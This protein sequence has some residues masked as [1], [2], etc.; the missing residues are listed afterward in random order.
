MYSWLY[1]QT[2]PFYM[3]SPC[4]RTGRTG[5]QLSSTSEFWGVGGCEFSLEGFGRYGRS[6]YEKKVVIY[7]L[8]VPFICHLYTI[9]IYHLYMY[10]IRSMVDKSSMNVDG[11]IQQQIF[12]TPVLLDTSTEQHDLELAGWLPYSKHSARCSRSAPMGDALRINSGK[13]AGAL[14][15]K[16]G[17]SCGQHLGETHSIVSL[18]V[19]RSTESNTIWVV[20]QIGFL[21]HATTAP[22]TFVSS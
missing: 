4:T 11:F 1:R 14:L 10:E 2:S 21:D 7:H 19:H 22:L 8:Y 3:A 16:T 13:Y 18:G 9:F 5:G 12:I 6:K 20:A 17:F 15:A